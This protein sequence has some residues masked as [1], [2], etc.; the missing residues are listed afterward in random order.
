[1]GKN[2]LAAFR[3]VKLEYGKIHV[4]GGYVTR[5]MPVKSKTIDTADGQAKTFV[6]LASTE[7]WLITSTTGHLL[8]TGLH[9]R[10]QH[11][12]LTYEIM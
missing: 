2:V 8:E 1:M 9:S 6:K 4:S 12:W 3:P 11:Y 5:P 10:A 7:S